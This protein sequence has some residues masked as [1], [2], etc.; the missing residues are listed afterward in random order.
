M[1]YS[2]EDFEG[3]TVY[4][5]PEGFY[6]E[7]TPAYD[8]GCLAGDK[9][10]H[11]GGTGPLPKCPYDGQAGREWKNGFNSCSGEEQFSID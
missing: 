1:T 5:G 10:M 4:D 2:R 7:T 11:E 9:W 3:G 8:A 6:S